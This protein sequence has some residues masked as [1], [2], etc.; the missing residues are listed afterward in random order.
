ML[1]FEL[2]GA[3]FQFEAREPEFVVSFQFPPKIAAIPL[4]PYLD[5]AC[6]LSRNLE[7]CLLPQASLLPLDVD[8][9]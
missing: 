4:I 3:L 6:A 7:F 5:F 8:E 1:L 2:E 9:P